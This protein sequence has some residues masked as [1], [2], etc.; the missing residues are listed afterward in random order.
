[1]DITYLKDYKLYIKVT[2]VTLLA[3][4]LTLI[5]TQIIKIILNK[6]KV[7]KEETEAS[8]KD[9]ILARTGRIVAL[10]VYTIMYLINEWIINKTI[11]FDES[12]ITG[13]ITGASLTLSFAKGIYTTL[14]QWS[15]KKN[16]YERLE[17][18][19]EVNNE[20]IQ[21]IEKISVDNKEIT[22]RW[23]LTNKGVKNK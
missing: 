23:T 3:S 22:N 5:I 13:I 8:K 6:K 7:I 17:Y 4:I 19:E 12:L 9:E 15:E 10:I 18:A 2:Y 20:L 1:M 16:I 14:H 11:I 21:T